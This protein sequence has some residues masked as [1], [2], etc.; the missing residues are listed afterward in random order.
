MARK[1]KPQRYPQSE[2]RMIKIDEHTI[3]E[4]HQSVSDEQAI[5]DYNDKRKAHEE[6][7]SFKKDNKIK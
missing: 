4:V 2:M 3:I 1:S 5:K 7:R 6:F